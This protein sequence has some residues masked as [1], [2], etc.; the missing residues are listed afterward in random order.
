[1]HI[2][3]LQVVRELFGYKL[4]TILDFFFFFKEKIVFL[5]IEYTQ[6]FNVHELNPHII[7]KRGR[8]TKRNT[9]KKTL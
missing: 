1:M 9:I 6:F 2:Q 4:K 3:K 8:K 5:T 7:L